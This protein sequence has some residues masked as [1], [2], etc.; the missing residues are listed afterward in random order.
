MATGQL[1]CSNLPAAVKSR[2]RYGNGKSP[3]MTLVA[4]ETAR[5]GEQTKLLCSI[6]F[7]FTNLTIS[8]IVLHNGHIQ[9]LSFF[10]AL[11]S[12]NVIKRKTKQTNKQ[13]KSSRESHFARLKCL[14][15]VLKHER[16]LNG[17]PHRSAL[18][19]LICVL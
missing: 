12:Q 14:F 17:I 9:N 2:R 10:S 3:F 7:I 1:V 18:V 19:V 5:A 8:T 16:C 4:R 6:F 13:K 11:T 15:K